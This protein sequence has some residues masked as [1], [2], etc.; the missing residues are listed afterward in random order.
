[1]TWGPR[2]GPGFDYT[3]IHN[4]TA[5]DTLQIPSPHTLLVTPRAPGLEFSNLLTREPDHER[6]APRL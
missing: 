1:M 4:A 6:I 3:P 5:L 2:P